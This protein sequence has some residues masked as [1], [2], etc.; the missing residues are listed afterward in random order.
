VTPTFAVGPYVSY[1]VGWYSGD[2]DA[3]IAIHSWL[4]LGARANFLFF[5]P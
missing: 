4:Q 1:S 2:Q 3:V 5:G